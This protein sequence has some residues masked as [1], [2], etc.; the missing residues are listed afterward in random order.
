MPH[1]PLRR[2]LEPPCAP[3]LADRRAL[4]RPERPDV[5]PHAVGKKASPA[6]R[7]AAPQVFEPA[8]LGPLTLRNRIVKAATFEGV[9]PGGAVSDELIAFHR[10]VGGR[11]RGHDH[12]RLPR[13]LARGAHR[14]SLRAARRRRRA[15]PA[16]PHRRRARRGRGRRG[17][18][19]PRRSGRQRP[20]QPRPALS[21]SGGFTPMGSRLRAVDLGRHRAHHRGLP[22]RRRRWPSRRASTASRSTSG[23]TTS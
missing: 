23:T 15:R 3:T 5:R 20:L 7:T 4:L 19:R 2:R 17:P 18:D 12:G 14:P 10:R 11:R 13:R 6:D 16:A 22:A 1:L 21:P 9:M 8:P